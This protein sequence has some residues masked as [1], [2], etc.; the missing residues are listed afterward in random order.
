[1]DE[2]YGEY[3]TSKDFPN[4]LELLKEYPN[5]IILKTLSKAYGLASLRFG[6]G[7]AKEEIVDYLNRVINSFDV[8][9]F[10]QRAAL[11]AIEDED[12]ISTVKEYNAR[13]RES[14]YKAFKE[15][16]LEYIHSEGNFIMVNV[17]GD[18]KSIHEY[19]LRN[20]YIIRPGYLLDMPGWIRV[21]LGTREQNIEFCDLLKKAIENRDK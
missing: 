4:S 7:I 18:D 14:L 17:K 13:E 11:V 3:V 9:L 1:M 19:L 8:N 10:A 2:A 16:G 6:Y 15:M 20:G 21:S 12:F 5:M